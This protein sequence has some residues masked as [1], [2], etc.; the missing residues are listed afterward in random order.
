MLSALK[1]M[2]IAACDP[3]YEE[4]QREL[5]NLRV[6]AQQNGGYIQP[7]QWYRLLGADG[8]LQGFS[9]TCCQQYQ[10]RDAALWLRAHNCPQCRARI[11]VLEFVGI[12]PG[13][14]PETWPGKFATLPVQP[15][16]TTAQKPGNF[17]D[18]WAVGLDDVAYS[19]SDPYAVSKQRGGN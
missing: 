5:R 16:S 17:Q 9:F 7:G 14:K 3:R 12:K 13:D 18:T 1:R 11:S 10:L 2:V 4:K 6:A 8:G 19:M 15:A